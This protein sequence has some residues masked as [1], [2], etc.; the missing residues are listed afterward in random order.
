MR[1]LREA[2]SRDGVV[3]AAS[4]LREML[5]GDSRYGDPLSTAGREPHALMGRTVSA[6]STDRP[7]A[8]RELGLGAL[9][10]WQA[11]SE[12]Q[13]RGRG[14]QEVTLLFTDLVGFSSW[15]L[16]AGDAAAVELLRLVGIEVE[17]A[18]SDHH[19]RIVKRLGDGIMA[20]FG[21][22]ADGVRAGLEAQRRLQGVEVEGHRP[23]MRAGLHCG[24]PRRLG[25]DYLGQDVNIAARV[26]EAAGPGEVL[27]S[28]C[29]C[30]R[31]DAAEFPAGRGKR[32]KASGAP[33]QMRVHTVG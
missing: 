7:S 11:L 24:R 21:D 23:R 26:A 13:G 10:V 25:G 6:L 16:E 29:V 8:A 4:R 30:D 31:L 19:G 9:Q 20:V 12:A 18:V 5:P 32:L 33:P 28:D 1:S 15:A 14:D 27:V 17:G 22:P 3:G 2:N